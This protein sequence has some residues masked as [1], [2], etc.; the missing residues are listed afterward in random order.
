VILQIGVPLAAALTSFVFAIMVLARWVRRR[1]LHNLLWGIGLLLFGT[2]ALMEVLYQSSGWSPLVFQL[3]Y[4]SGAF[5]A[6]A[7]LG[8]GTVY[9]LTKKRYAHALMAVLLVGSVAASVA[10]F[11]AP[12]D[13]Q[14]VID[15]GELTGQ[16]L[17]KNVRLL[18][19]PFNTYGTLG[20]AGGAVYSAWLFWRKRVMINRVVGNL[21]IGLGGIL[22][23]FA[24]IMSRL[25]IP[26]SLYIGL[27][28][29]AVLMFVGFL[30]TNRPEAATKPA[31]ASV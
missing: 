12:L 30:Q 23:A 17:P 9:L 5:F 2:G 31:Q 8:Q 6:A 20:L 13:A 7:Y 26:R 27:F 4:F 10:L 18:T 24:G 3:W 15:F 1:A 25:G 11:S 29:G 22:P 16:A 19:I 14:A 21:L 28:L